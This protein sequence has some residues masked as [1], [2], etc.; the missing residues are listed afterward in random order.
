MKRRKLITLL[1]VRGGNPSIWNSV[2][3]REGCRNATQVQ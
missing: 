1:G 2:S 3:R